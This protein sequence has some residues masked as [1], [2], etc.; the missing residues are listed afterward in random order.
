MKRIFLLVALI[1]T[2]VITCYAQRI[3]F[4]YNYTS[5]GEPIQPGSTWT[6]NASGGNVYILF[7]NGGKAFNASTISFYIDYLSGTEYKVWDTKVVNV[8]PSNTW[9][10]LDYKFTSAGSYR[11]AVWVNGYEVA[12]DYVTITSSSGSSGSS[13]T[14]SSSTMYYSG[15]SVLAGT[16]ID[17][18]SGYVY[19][20]NGPFYL[21]AQYQSKVYFKVSNGT[22]KLGTSKLIADIY[23]M[24]SSGT[25]DF[26]TTKNYDITDLDWVYFTYDFNAAGSYKVSVYNSTSVWINN[27]FVTINSNTSSGSGTGTGTGDNSRVASGNTTS[28]GTSTST[29]YYSGSSVVPGTNVDAVSGYV[30]GMYGP[31]QRKSLINKKVT[32]Y[33]KVS[34]GDKKL[35]TTRLIVDIYKKNKKGNYEFFTTKYYDITDLNWVYFTYEFHDD[36]Q[37]EVNVH[38]SAGTWINTAYV[39]VD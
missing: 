12:K 20:L 35:N 23:K 11:V 19:G 9:Q 3:Y 18:S 33:F 29:M 4:C 39:T 7:Q 31:F 5:A 15:S 14:T 32:V 38:N 17:A 13:T 10:V 28:T 22:K 27:V 1:M 21:N 36:G 26:Y 24:N 37:Y 34:N 25:Y 6:I 8:S 2:T 30:T 16:S